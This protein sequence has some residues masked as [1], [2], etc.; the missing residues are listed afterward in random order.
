MAFNK[1][2]NMS[3][4]SSTSP[5]QNE[6]ILVSDDSTS[7]ESIGDN[8][9]IVRQHVH[10]RIPS[11]ISTPNP[12]SSSSMEASN[13]SQ[14]STSIPE[15]SST[16]PPSNPMV[17]PGDIPS[18]VVPRSSD[19]NSLPDLT[20]PESI[21]IS[22]DTTYNTLPDL[23]LPESIT[24]SSDTTYNSLPD[25]IQEDSDPI[26]ISED[27]DNIIEVP[28]VTTDQAIPGP[29]SKRKS[30]PILFPMT[31]KARPAANVSSPE[32]LSDSPVSAPE[33]IPEPIS[34]TEI[35]EPVSD[36]ESLPDTV[37][38]T[39]HHNGEIIPSDPSSGDE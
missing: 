13:P 2:N 10:L 34:D 36:I 15:S 29:S 30:S 32:S 38:L 8:I 39:Y 24:I 25:L 31:K 18:A 9:E 16:M 6:P 4:D 19:S 11:Q 33:I 3:S 20:L 26:I 28:Y 17:A 37:I 22:S 23:T 14:I 21:S 35:P 7:N 1:D 5:P 27:S 12:S